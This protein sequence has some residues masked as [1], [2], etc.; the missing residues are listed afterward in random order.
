MISA[1][2]FIIIGDVHVQCT[3]YSPFIVLSPKITDYIKTRKNYC[4]LLQLGG[5]EKGDESSDQS[6]T[7]SQEDNKQVILSL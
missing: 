6:S 3:I 2:L 1:I 7:T 5:K 4:V